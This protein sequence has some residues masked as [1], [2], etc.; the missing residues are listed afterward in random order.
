[1]LNPYGFDGVLQSIRASFR[2]ALSTSTDVKNAIDCGKSSRPM[3]LK[4]KSPFK[5]CISLD[6][7]L[8]KDDLL[9]CSRRTISSV[10]SLDA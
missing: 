3:L 2:S 4:K 8:I 9:T 6:I 5:E 10:N 1:M 7:I